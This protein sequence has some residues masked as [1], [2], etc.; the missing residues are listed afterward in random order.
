MPRSRR[1]IQLEDRG[2]ER[3]LKGGA[4]FFTIMA[5]LCILYYL[6][7]VLFTGTS[8]SFIHI[9]ALMGAGSGVI[10]VLCGKPAWRRRI[11]KWLIRLFWIGV[12]AGLAI[13]LF[14]EGLVMTRYF[15]SAPEDADVMIV[16]GAQW[17]Q[18]GPSLVLKYRLDRAIQYLNENPQTIVIVSGGQGPDEPI[19]EAEGMA[20][21][22]AAAGVDPERIY[23]EDESTNTYENLKF[24]K[25][26]VDKENDEIVLV[27][28]NYHVFRAE[29][30]ARAQGYRNIH[31]LAARG[32]LPLQ[33]NNLVREF[34]GVMKDFLMGNMVSWER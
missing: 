9:W 14:V 18:H 12:A 33:P 27:T 1:V 25:D 8:T 21:Y 6:A 11:P 23:Q 22:L 31:G 3:V 16:L 20:G 24:S 13:F 28:S 15:A 34:C 17:K 26:M 29:K 2:P 30:L 5:V 19:S 10:A 4:I 7:I 32:Y